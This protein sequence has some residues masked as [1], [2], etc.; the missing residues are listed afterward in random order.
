[1]K[2][3]ETAS[4]APKLAR[5]RLNK[6]YMKRGPSKLKRRSGGNLKGSARK[7]KKRKKI[8]DLWRE[9]LVPDNAYRRFTG[10]RGIYWYWL[11]RDVRKSEWEKW[12]KLCLT[13]LLP[14]ER[15]EDGQCGHVIASHGCGEYLRLNRI[16]LTIQHSHCNNSRFTP[17]AGGL[18]AVHYDQRYGQGAYDRLWEMVKIEAKEPKQEEYRELIRALPS[19]QEVAQNKALLEQEKLSPSPIDNT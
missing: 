10:L 8:V 12:D 14:I 16:N 1:M 13:C 3:T 15:W 19:Y 7:P 4:Y 9:W 11:S 17:N 5:K 6:V 2:V 18:N